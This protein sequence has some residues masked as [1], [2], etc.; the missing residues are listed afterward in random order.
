LKV[1]YD[2]IVL[3]TKWIIE[4]IFY[5]YIDCKNKEEEK[6]IKAHTINL[7]FSNEALKHFYYCFLFV[8]TSNVRS[9]FNSSIAFSSST[10]Q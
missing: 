3:N 10:D 4:T 7:Q 5:K 1:L 2:P 9:G 8:T 6:K